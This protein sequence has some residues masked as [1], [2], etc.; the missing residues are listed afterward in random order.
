MQAPEEHEEKLTEDTA[1]PLEEKTYRD[2]EG[3]G[4][5]I[6]TVHPPDGRYAVISCRAA[7]PV[8]DVGVTVHPADPLRVNMVVDGPDSARVNFMG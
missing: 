6:V 3:A 1:V 7:S 4:A 2:V 8:I 5:L